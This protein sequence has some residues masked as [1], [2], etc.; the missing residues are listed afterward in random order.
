MVSILLRRSSSEYDV[1]GMLVEEETKFRE[2]SIGMR[3]MKQQEAR[4]EPFTAGRRAFR[5]TDSRRTVST[6]L[7]P[8]P[9]PLHHSAGKPLIQAQLQTL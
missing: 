4:T 1:T 9:L 7:K 6:V 5:P 2:E 3:T 8:L